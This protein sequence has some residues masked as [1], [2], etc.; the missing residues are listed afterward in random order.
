[1]CSPATFIFAVRIQMAAHW[2][3]KPLRHGH[4][5]KAEKE[6]TMG[7]VSFAFY[8]KV[9]LL[10]NKSSGQEAHSALRKYGC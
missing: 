3:I 2:D 5:P 6:P 10:H 8:V 1:M 7:S 9:L 4:T